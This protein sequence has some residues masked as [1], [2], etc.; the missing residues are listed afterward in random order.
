VESKKVDVL[1]VERFWWLPDIG[2]RKAEG[3]M[4]KGSSMGPM[5]FIDWRNKS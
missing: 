3:G 1:E 4:K 2:E 5:L